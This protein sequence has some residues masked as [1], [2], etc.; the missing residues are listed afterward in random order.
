MQSEPAQ[1]GQRQH[2]SPSLRV[3]LDQQV[4]AVIVAKRKLGQ[5]DDEVP[6][7]LPSMLS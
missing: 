6:F 2:R 1:C 4:P 3:G 5:P 7:V